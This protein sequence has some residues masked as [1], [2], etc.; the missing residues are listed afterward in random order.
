MNNIPNL[1]KMYNEVVAYVREHQ[2]EKGYIDCQPFM[3]N[4]GDTIYGFLFNEE[5]GVNEEKYIYAVRVDGN[6]LECLFEDI[7]RSCRVVYGPEDFI[8][9]EN[10]WWSV[11]YSDVAYIPTIFN[12]AENIE[13]YA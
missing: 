11:R 5:Y 6:D 1:D 10:E 9:G 7:L 2:G 13:E 4:P 8:N 12:I 3:E